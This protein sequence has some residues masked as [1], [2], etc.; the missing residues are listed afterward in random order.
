MEHIEKIEALS[1]KRKYWDL[2]MLADPDEAMVLKYLEA[3]EMFVL[4][5]EARAVSEAVI[6]Q[7]GDGHPELKNFATGEAHQRRG[8]G[9][10]LIAFLFERY[11]GRPLY[12]GTAFPGLYER[13]GFE[14]AYTIPNFFTDNYPEPII[15]G[16]RQCVDMI[17]Y[18]K[19]L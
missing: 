18:K 13:W 5:D 17:Y 14:Y 2:L 8:Y 11:K 4:F 16:G 6:A 19:G 10:K 15:D 7:R 1:D 12:V 3:G 9:S